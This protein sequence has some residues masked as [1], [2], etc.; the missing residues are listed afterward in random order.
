[1]MQRIRHSMRSD[2]HTC[3]AYDTRCAAD[4]LHMNGCK[5]NANCTKNGSSKRETAGVAAIAA[6][7]A[8]VQPTFSAVH[9]QRQACRNA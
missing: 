2:H 8:S 6:I 9:S 7:M 3:T 1:M 4:L 5:K